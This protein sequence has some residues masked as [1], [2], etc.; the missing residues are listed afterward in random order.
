M[1]VKRIR[2]FT[3]FIILV[4][5][6]SQAF[7][8]DPKKFPPINKV[9]YDGIR[10]VRMYPSKNPLDLPIVRLNGGGVELHFDDMY[11]GAS[12]Y[13]YTIVHCNAD[14]TPS[15]L[16]KSDYIDG[17]Q[18]YFLSDFDY[19]FN[20]FVP[21]SHFRLR[22]PNKDMKFTKSGNYLLI[23]FEKN[24]E[25]PVLTRRFL[26]YES[27]TNIEG[28]I[29][30]PT[31]LDRMNTHQQ[32]HFRI[33]HPGYTIPDPARDI[34][35]TVLQNQDWTKVITNLEPQYIQND[36][37]VYERDKGNS[38]PG[39]N[40]YRF[41]DTKN[42]MVLTQNI[43]K[44]DIDSIFNVFLAI[45]QL[46]FKGPYVYW[47][48]INGMYVVRRLDA[49]N[50]DLSADYALVD[51]FL[52][53]PTRLPGDVYVFGELSNWE[54]QEEFKLTYNP[55]RFAYQGKILLKQ[56]YYNYQYVTAIPSP[57]GQKYHAS[58]DF[59]EGNH[60][61][62]ENAYHVMVYHREIGIRYDRLVGYKY[63]QSQPS[64]R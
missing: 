51:F 10:T 61:E 42:L 23:I 48:D 18:E 14:W 32:L 4:P 50:Y 46:R 36:Q 1:F 26:V 38:F 22:L 19:S 21:F 16:R 55:E 52:E 29:R 62:T 17:Y 64:N 2:I 58:L 35:V 13:Q 49:A 39:G 34:K 59:T 45:D 11:E 60:W 28:F 56:G 40:E 5:L 27:F 47:D 53:S 12:D 20:T 43:R 33:N 24:A 63:F 8:Y 54:L 3:V 57:D 25:Y 31:E 44:I 9:Y 30:R 7:E 15:D 41:F 6:L 37:M